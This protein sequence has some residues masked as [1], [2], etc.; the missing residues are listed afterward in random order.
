MNAPLATS[1]RIDQF[2]G[3]LDE[4]N[5]LELKGWACN[6]TESGQ[7]VTL[8]VI[9][10]DR[11]IARVTCDLPRPD[12]EQNIGVAAPS[13]GF[14]FILPDSV[15]DGK[16]HT[17]GLRFPNRSIV[18]SLAGGGSPEE[19]DTRTIFQSSFTY[20]SF[21]D[22]FAQGAVRGWVQRLN[23]ATGERE[24]QCDLTVLM[25]GVPFAHICA[26]RFRGDV[27]AATGGDPNCG[28]ELVIPRHKRSTGLTTLSFFVEPG[29]V[30]LEG[31]P[32]TTSLVDDKLEEHLLSLNET[33]GRLHREIASLRSQIVNLLPEQRYN[34]ADYDSWTRRY[35][36]S[37]RARVAARRQTLGEAFVENGPLVSIICPTY[38][39]DMTDFIAAVE[40]V[41]AQT[42]SKWEL[43]VVDDG[44]KS[45]EV[46]A[47]MADYCRNDPR[48]RLIRL[49]TNV[50]IAEATNE[51]IKAAKG[52]WIAFFDHDD[53]MVDVALEAMLQAAHGRDPLVIYS[54]EDK[55]DKA[56]Y[57]S[58]PNFKPDFDYR[59]LLG[60]NYICHLT[61]VRTDILR[62]TGELRAAYDGAQDH[63]LMLRLTEI[64][65]REN[66]L[67]VPE[68]LYHWRKSLNSTAA[69]IDSKQYAVSAG[70]RCVAD[71]LK[72]VG[73]KALVEAIDN[74]PI[75]NIRW[76]VPQEPT[77]SIIIPFRDQV[78]TTRECVARILE[79]TAYKKYDI[80]LVD[81]WSLEKETLEFCEE[82]VKDK[83]ISVLSV[84]EEFNFSR[85]NNLAAAASSSEFY[86]FMNNDL[87]V[88]NRNWLKTIVGEALAGADIGAVG[89]KF[90]YP[91]GAVQHAGVVVGP[92][93]VGVH[94][95]RGLR[96]SDHGYMGRAAVS[97]EI[98]AVTAAGMLVR[99]EAFRE[100]G[101]FDE[102][103]L[104][105]AYND[106]DLCL[107]LRDAGWRIIQCN[108]FVAVHHESLSRGSDDR[109]E[110]E[111][112]FFGE[113]QYMQQRWGETEIYQRD[114]TY[115]PHLM[116]E[117][118]YYDLVTPE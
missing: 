47:R 104:K 85:L 46:A 36:A 74:L 92:E 20:E 43:I 61:M 67:H 6:L 88:E 50:G 109:P 97:H 14:Q 84:K 55:I 1:R 60:C 16:E 34:L 111:A 38:K 39:P 91:N 110:H 44:G 113:T 71:H 3:Y 80:I 68:I 77:V 40:S 66:F 52:E 101:G 103:N 82:I 22:G 93:V 79:H 116:L 62:K 64:V 108:S 96:R 54:D 73:Y 28:F 29:H 25:G 87:F 15:A 115:S 31:S 63:D 49:K 107:K 98:T 33:V 51:G 53:V 70:T 21:V 11:E 2:I 90:F 78:E 65:P 12:V 37:L 27:A 41:M 48:I 86:F 117:Q 57:L 75:Y 5:G 17:I 7:P 118:S 114:P 13:L 23:A 56:G 58:E 10:D 89:G 95:H 59:Y 112:R 19:K 99:A 32:V 81:N 94:V 35:F 106:V 30:E 26:D 4:I 24:G 105:V 76:A 42:W 8:H 45:L 18:P 69:T 9:L 83:R 100:V 72:R 102:E